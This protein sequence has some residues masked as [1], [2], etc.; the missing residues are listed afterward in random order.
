MHIR[1]TNDDT[2]KTNN[3]TSKTNNDIIKTNN[4]VRD[5]ECGGPDISADTED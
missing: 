1:K 2:S 4:A 5:S 3:N